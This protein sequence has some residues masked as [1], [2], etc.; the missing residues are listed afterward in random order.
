VARL[1]VLSGALA[2]RARR[3]VLRLRAVVGLL[4]LLRPALPVGAGHGVLAA[5]AGL[6]QQSLGLRARR[7]QDRLGIA[8][9]G[10]LRGLG[11]LL[12]PPLRRLGALL[13]LGD[14]LV[15]LRLDPLGP[16]L[17]LLE[18]PGRLGLRL[19]EQPLTLG[20]DPLEL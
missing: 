16:Q 18:Q 20:L 10:L 3:A 4:V 14:D 19:G 15:P 5:P 8:P 17:G 7:R 12:G 2:A 6:L 11:Q 13:G 1:P 9:R